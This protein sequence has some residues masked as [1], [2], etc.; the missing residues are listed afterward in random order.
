MFESNSIILVD[1]HAVIG[2]ASSCLIGLVVKNFGDLRAVG[3]WV[4][5]FNYEDI[6]LFGSS[7][8]DSI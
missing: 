4:S 6:L 2:L 1:F 5:I 8:F 3:Y 7:S